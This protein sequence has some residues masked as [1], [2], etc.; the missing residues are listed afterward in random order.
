MNKRTLTRNVAIC[1]LLALAGSAWAGGS[2]FPDQLLDFADTGVVAGSPPVITWLT[3][4]LVLVTARRPDTKAGAGLTVPTKM[5]DLVAINLYTGHATP[6][7]ERA[8]LLCW[9]ARGAFGVVRVAEPPNTNK[10]LTWD[11]AAGFRILDVPAQKQDCQSQQ[12]TQRQD[13]H[14]IDL[15]LGNGVIRVPRQKG[16]ESQPSY[17]NEQGVERQLALPVGASMGQPWY[18]PWLDEY[19]IGTTELGSVRMRADGAARDAGDYSE[20]RK[21]FSGPAMQLTNAGTVVWTGVFD[22]EF[23]GDTF[24]IPFGQAPVRI[25]KSKGGWDQLGPVSIGPDGCG[26]LLSMSASGPFNRLLAL[27]NSAPQTLHYVDI[28]RTFRPQ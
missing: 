2:P 21:H 15:G 23:N 11:V 5:L 6:I 24:F 10:R 8:Q 17:I 26:A 9:A 16:P 18:I 14:D 27:A 28:C 22:P 12:V 4:K 19:S 25:Y 3:P 1:L 20:P 13:S 7:A